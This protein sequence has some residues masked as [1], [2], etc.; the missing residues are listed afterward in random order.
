MKKLVRD[1]F[2]NLLG[3]K[4]IR[5]WA[6]SLQ[7]D[8]IHHLGFIYDKYYGH[9]KS[10]MLQKPVD[11]TGDFLPWFTYPAI[12]YLSQLDLRTKKV[13]EWGSGYSSV[14]F[15]KRSYKVISIE[16]SADWYTE[17]KNF[18]MPNHKIIIADEMEYV[19]AA[20]NL[21]EV[22]DVIVIDGIKRAECARVAPMLLSSNGLIVFDN[23]DR[24][25]MI[26]KALRENDYIQV[27]MHG[28][29][30]INNYTWTTSL[31][32]TRKFDFLPLLNQPVIPLGGGF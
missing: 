18:E 19:E 15:A 31:F 24:D 10:R 20:V 6:C 17:V 5:H 13:L 27:D 30:P 29:G 12:E 16:H 8:A 28:A 1:I 3:K 14:F 9:S 23:A 26:C 21:D 4:R 25:P 11:A 22:F 7:A 2:I 32:F